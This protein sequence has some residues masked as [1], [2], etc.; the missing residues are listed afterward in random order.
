VQH[1]RIALIALA[2]VVA[3]GGK[4]EAGRGVI[5]ITSGDDVFHIRDLP[6]ATAAEI[7]YGK[8]GYHYDYFGVFW[9]DLW[10]SGGEFCVYRGNT[11]VVLDDKDLEALGGASV[12]WKYH[13]P[14]GLLAILA[15]IAVGILS[16]VRR[17]VKT[18]FILAGVFAAIAILFFA[19]GLDWEFMI[20]GGIAIWLALA[21]YI[22][23]K[24]QASH[25]ME[26]S[27]TD[28]EPEPVTPSGAHRAAS[29]SHRAA[30]PSQ[31]PPPVHVPPVEA[32]PV[33]VT[34][35]QTQPASVPM[36][37][38]DSAEGPKLLR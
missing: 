21:G 9:L 38:D 3:L 1:V 20:P 23:L 7:G 5:V 4:A 37:A 33:V 10:R 17:R 15:L 24:R 25:E 2:M 19:K 36:R 35:A 11:Y 6:A 32:Q 14:P 18:V 31:P 29:G 34:R 30:R 16:R 27:T 13:L 26:L 8:L 28:V 22:T 12:P